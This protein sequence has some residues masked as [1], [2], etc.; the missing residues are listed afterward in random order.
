V[1]S[2]KAI[3]AMAENRVIGCGGA[4]PWRLP[5]DF[6]WFKRT[7]GGQIVVM[8][9]KTYESIG[10]PLPGRRN[11]VLT[12]RAWSSPGIETASDADALDRAIDGDEREVWIAGGAE[13]YA[14]FL[15]R[16]S[17]LFLTRV[18]QTPKGDAFFPPFEDRFWLIG[19]VLRTP[20]F[21]VE[22]YQARNRMLA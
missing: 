10:K 21:A 20:D 17:D 18:F 11:I 13:V 9:R 14:S 19:E 12:R 15:S 1:R 7:T 2:F 5:A 22:H 3:A 6:Q 16:C 8:G 4:L